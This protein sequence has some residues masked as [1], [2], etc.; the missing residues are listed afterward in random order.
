MYQEG[1]SRDSHLPC[2]AMAGLALGQKWLVPMRLP[3][4]SFAASRTSL[5]DSVI[6][7]HSCPSRTSPLSWFK[8]PRAFPRNVQPW[9]CAPRQLAKKR[10]VYILDLKSAIGGRVTRR[11]RQANGKTSAYWQTVHLVHGGEDR[12]KPY[13][14]RLRMR[15]A[16]AH[17]KQ[18][19]T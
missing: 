19:P 13:R 11:Q 12:E 15:R 8:Y 10:K 9:T 7:L 5:K 2:C 1:W 3:S 4:R 16:A 17:I 6:Y 14:E 18:R